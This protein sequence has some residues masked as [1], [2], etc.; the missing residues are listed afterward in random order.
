MTE[1]KLNF[2]CG[3]NIL[4]GWTNIDL[5]EGPGVD[6]VVDL[7]AASWTYIPFED[8]SVDEFLLSHVLEHVRHTLDLM[9]EIY[10]IAKP[11]AR[12]TIR[13]PYGSS[14]DAFEDPTHVRPYF[15]DSFMYF[16]QPMYW[17]ADYGYRGDWQPDL[18]TLTLSEARYGKV[19]RT[20]AMGEI[21]G[22]RNVVLE[23]V[24]ELHAVKPIREAKAELQLAPEVGIVLVDDNNKFVREL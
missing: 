13:L 19:S 10:R 1:L 15:A 18:V 9:R 4:E 11:G 16:S 17:K 23:M 14:N 24:C 20:Q 8:D 5:N 3:K 2:G 21:M 6:L 12:M 7:D 22:Y